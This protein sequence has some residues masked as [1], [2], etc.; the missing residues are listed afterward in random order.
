MFLK[1]L[2]YGIIA[3]WMVLALISGYLTIAS[4]FNFQD[5]VQSL[6]LGLKSIKSSGWSWS[7]PI[8]FTLIF[9]ARPILLIPTFVMNIVAFAVFGLIE[10]FFIVLLAEQISALT[11]FVGVKHLAG[12]GLKS[13]F[14]KLT[15]KMRLNVDSKSSKQ[16]NLV[17]V[18]R[19]ASLPFDFVTASCALSGVRLVPFLLATFIV[20]IP[21]VLLFFLVIS[22]VSTGSIL[23][24]ILNSVIFFGFI[25]ISGVV[26]KR[27][28][29][30]LPKDKKSEVLD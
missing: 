14:E 24:T 16:F 12:E 27:S 1:Y 18:L 26:A 20:S 2:K 7:L 11:F 3:L 6:E 28:G 25:L 10:G 19:L 5:M 17:A 29:L 13:S 8:V 9:T 21:W 4:N 15:K 22:S 23:E 30:I